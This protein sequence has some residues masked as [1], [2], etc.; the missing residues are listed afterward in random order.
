MWETVVRKVGLNSDGLTPPLFT[1]RL[2]NFGPDILAEV[3][4]NQFLLSF[5]EA[6]QYCVTRPIIDLQ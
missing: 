5:R 1:K 4:E 2:T 3:M 6:R